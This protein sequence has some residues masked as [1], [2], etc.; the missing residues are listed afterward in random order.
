MHAVYLSDPE[1]TIMRVMSLKE[2]EEMVMEQCFRDS[3]KEQRE[4]EKKM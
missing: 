1:L 2:E 4:I 3:V